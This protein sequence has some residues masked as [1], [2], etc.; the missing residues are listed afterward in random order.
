MRGR[1]SKKIVTVRRDVKIVHELGLHA[2]PAA[3]FV[4]QANSFYSDIWLIKDGE[5]FI[6]TSL[7]D[8]LLA[9]IECGATVTL[10]ARGVDAELAI[11]VL[12]KLIAKLNAAET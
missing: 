11:D 5:R 7:V 12:E 8:V 1:E 4:S 3:Q 2:R 9:N 6:G 10:E